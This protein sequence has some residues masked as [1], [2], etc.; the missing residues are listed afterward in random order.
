[1][2]QLLNDAEIFNLN[3]PK[4]ASYIEQSK[5]AQKVGPLKKGDGDAM[6]ILTIA[7]QQRAASMMQEK[8]FNA[9]L[10]PQTQLFVP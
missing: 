6:K 1:M 9:Q 3:L 4:L 7:V 10:S 2:E 8:E 5:L